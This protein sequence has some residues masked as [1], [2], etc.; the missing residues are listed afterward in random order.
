MFNIITEH[1][2]FSSCFKVNSTAH[3]YG[4]AGDAG[5]TRR[6]PILDVKRCITNTILLY[7]LFISIM[8]NKQSKKAILTLLLSFCFKV[9]STAHPY[10]MAGDAEITP[11]ALL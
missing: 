6:P 11:K 3:P 1:F 5:I 7:F 10:G 8:Q 9:R 2:L 4:T